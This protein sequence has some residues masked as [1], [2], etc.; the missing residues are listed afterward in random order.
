MPGKMPAKNNLLIDTLAATPKI[1]KPIEGGIMGPITPHAA[2]NP[3]L[4]AL[5]WPALTIMGNNNA[6]NAAASATAEPDSAD[7]RQAATM[8]TYPKPPRMCPTKAIAKSTIRLDKPPVFMTS[9]ANIKNGTARSGKL[10]EPSITFCANICASNMF[11]CHIKAA[12][13]SN[14][15]KAIGTPSAMAAS[16]DPKNTAIVIVDF[17][18]SYFNGAGTSIGSSSDSRT[19]INSLSANSPR[20]KRNTWSIKISAPETA[21][22]MP[23]A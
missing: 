7:K 3:T 16:K 12:P 14:K 5:S 13:H 8:V 9:P 23:Q 20:N 15:E 1:T 21:S 19:P 6:V 10:L 11:M 4:R 22:T 2:I 18:N 17:L